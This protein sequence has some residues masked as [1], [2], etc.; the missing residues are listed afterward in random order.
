MFSMSHAIT[1]TDPKTLCLRI[2]ERSPEGGLFQGDRSNVHPDSRLPWR[3]SP[4]P[5]WLT[6]EQHQ[7]LVD[8]GPVLYR[9]YQASN[10]L[11]Q[12]SVKGIQPAWIHRY[13]D[14]GKPDRIIDLGR[15]NRVKSQLPLV[16]RPDLLLTADG[17]RVTELDSVP[18]GIGFT[19]QISRLYADIGY[20]IVGGGDGLARGLY[21]AIRSSFPHDEPVVAV[22]V[23]DESEAYREEFEWLARHLSDS[24][25]PVHCCHPRDLHVDDDGI[26]VAD[27][28]TRVHIDV[29][30][31]FFELFDLANI[32]KAE[33][34]TYFSKK[35]AVRVTPPMKAYLEE[36]LW[37][38]LFHH[39][40]LSAFWETELGQDSWSSL[41]ELIPRT[42]VLDS[43]PAPPH[44][45]MPDLTLS[46]R[47]V[48]S[49]EEL[50]KCTKRERELVVKPS[51]FSDLA[52]HSKGVTIG[53]DEPEL[54]WAD[55]VQTALDSF[56]D[57]PY[58]LQAFHKAARIE[59]HYYDFY[60][61][62]MRTMHGRALLRP[63]YFVHDGQAELA[64]IQ[65]IVCPADK[66]I[67]HGMTDAVLMPCAVSKDA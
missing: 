7:F 31:R 38:A 15:L 19:G 59:A 35:N 20:D 45:V 46:G 4:E 50:K 1:E 56:P 44:T 43:T 58:L 36:K 3:I 29:V 42:W 34:I 23:S 24:G 39:P 2:N 63:Y 60:K 5:F 40:Q 53:H 16:M 52:Y 61:D 66:K 67:L 32:P 64:G 12:Q 25:L 48:S 47:P 33:L 62:S 54:V 28:D 30:Y 6:P 57:S 41:Q 18:G 55:A 13:L 22:V 14:A 9:F 17:V 10:L 49:W 65:A 26:L 11:Y 8:L 37:M 51:G 21:E 27:G